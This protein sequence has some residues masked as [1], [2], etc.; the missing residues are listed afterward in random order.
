MMSELLTLSGM[1]SRIKVDALWL[2]DM[3]KD[4]KIPCLKA[5]R[6]FLFNPSA[7]I[8]VLSEEAAKC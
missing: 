8:K 4:G 2:R 5:D 1:A 3:A 6:K 7:V